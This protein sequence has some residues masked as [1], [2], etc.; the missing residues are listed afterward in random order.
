MTDRCTTIIRVIACGFVFALCFPLGATGGELP[1][2]PP[3][4]G[5]KERCEGSQVVLCDALDDGRVKGV[6][7]TKRTPE[8]TLPEALA[9]KYRDWRW[10][11][12]PT[13]NGNPRAPAIDLKTKASGSGSLRFTIASSSDAND[14][15]YCQFDF[16]PDNS[17]QFGEGDSFF[18]QYRV[19][20]SCELLFVDCNPKSPTYKAERRRYR[21]LGRPPGTA[22]GGFKVSI[23][24]EGD[25]ARLRYP[26]SSCTLLE[27]AIVNTRQLGIIGGY[28][29]CG[30]YLGHTE[31]YGYRRGNGLFDVQPTGRRGRVEGGR[32]CWNLDLDSGHTVDRAS[33]DCVLWWADEWMTVTQEVTI[34]HWATQSKDPARSSN[35]RLWV[36]REGGPPILVFDHDLNL[37]MP[38]AP[39][40]KYGKIWL[41]PYHTN[42]DPVETHPEAYMWFDEL[43]VSRAPIPGAR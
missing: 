7:I 3:A 38:E 37:R 15:G 13:G 27:L 23:L 34:G 9:G 6:G 12:K 22:A 8:A 16:T 10:C 18:V 43:I 5:F 21:V 40:L 4:A 42:K 11:I 19:R 32:H 24:G 33:K 39:F 17:V 25:D 30:W 1:Q 20:F 35:Y 29:S 26:T 41:L 28:H 2:L 31:Y 14:S 36:S